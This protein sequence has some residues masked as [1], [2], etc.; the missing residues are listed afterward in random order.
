MQPLIS[1]FFQKLSGFSYKAND[2]HS[3]LHMLNGI[4]KNLLV[5][6]F[7]TWSNFCLQILNC[8]S[9]EIDG[10]NDVFSFEFS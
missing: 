1:D 10:E 8:F 4:L 2:K 3:L 7:E 9:P 6:G 5:I